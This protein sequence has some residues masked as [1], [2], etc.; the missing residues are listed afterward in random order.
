MSYIHT[1][2]FRVRTSE[3]NHR[4]VI[5][6]HALIQLMQEA[7]MQHT[8]GLQVS[9]WDM[10]SIHATWVLLKMDVKISH[11][12]KLNETVSVQTFPSGLNG[13]FTYRDYYM[14]GQ[15]GQLCATISS[16]WTLMNIETRKMMRIPLT[17]D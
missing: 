13:Y 6:P 15:D 1:E 5:H 17:F 8:L 12:P 11:Y 10:E 9:V 14:Y 2:I 16:M 3:I 4:K 7:S